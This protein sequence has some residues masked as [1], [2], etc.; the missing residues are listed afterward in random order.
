[1]AAAGQ[2]RKAQAHSTRRLPLTVPKHF[3]FILRLVQSAVAAGRKVNT[4]TKHSEWTA[5]LQDDCL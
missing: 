5:S 3:D 4:A 2:C 1:M